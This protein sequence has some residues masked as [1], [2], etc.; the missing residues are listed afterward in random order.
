MNSVRD[1]FNLRRNAP[2]AAAAFLHLRAAAAVATAT[3]SEKAADALEKGLDAI[4][5]KGKQAVEEAS[6]AAGAAAMSFTIPKNMPSFTNPQRTLEDQVWGS[7]GVTAR[8]RQVG[9]GGGGAGGIIGEGFDKVGGF[10]NPNKN[11]LPMYKDKPYAYPP[12]GRARPVYKRKS[13]LGLFVFLVVVV[14]YWFGIFE[15]H[16]EG[17]PS[18]KSA[19]WLKADK[20]TGGKADWNKRRERVV[21]AFELSWDGYE[22]YAWGML[23]PNPGAWRGTNA[24]LL[25]C[26]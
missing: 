20:A 7:S 6:I 1:P 11:T 16:Y 8:P 10:L 19:A 22:R 17:L 25:A 5:E 21:E 14:I 9:N 12:S 15:D 18:L 2:P 24:D 3:A 26:Y 4:V 13:C 23:L